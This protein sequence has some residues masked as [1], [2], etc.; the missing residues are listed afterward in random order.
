MSISFFNNRNFII[1][2]SVD[3][4]THHQLHHELVHF[5][6]KNNNRI[7]FIENTG[8]RN[9]QLK[10]FF[11]ISSRIKN[12]LKS[13]GG[14][15]LINKSLT[16][17]SPVFIPFHGNWIFDKINSLIINS[18]LLNWFSFT[19][20]KKPIIILFVPNPIS[21]SIINKIDYELLIYYVA[22]DMLLA[23][24]SNTAIKI[25]EEKIVK[26]SDLIVCT[27]ENLKRKFFKKKSKD[28][29]FLSNGVN[30]DKFKNLNLRKKI[31][32]DITI[33]FIGSIRNTI[34]QKLIIFLSK[35]FPDDRIVFVGPVIE[36]LQ[37]VIQKKLKNVFFLKQVRHSMIPK[38]L[39]NFDVGLLP[40]KVN[41]FTNSIFPIKLYEYLASGI[42]VL[43]TSTKTMIKFNDDNPNSV[44]LCKSLNDFEKRI[45]NIKKN[46]LPQEIRNKNI[47]LAHKNSWKIKFMEFEALLCKKYFSLQNKKNNIFDK[48]HSFY[49]YQKIRIFKISFVLLLS[50]L[51]F[52]V[53][54]NSKIFLKYYEINTK[55]RYYDSVIVITGFGLRGYQNISY[56]FRAKELIDYNK[57]INFKNI[58]IIGRSG[59]FDEG[60]LLVNMIDPE[61]KSKNI[62]II[63]DSGSTYNNVLK[64]KSLLD[65]SQELANVKNFSVIS[66]SIYSRRFQLVIKKNLPQLEID[67][68][69]Q[70]ESDSNYWSLLYEI[71]AI[72]KYKWNNHL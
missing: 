43:S 18:K 49:K 59:N 35:K 26:K 64:L 33:G 31:K 61:L 62:F 39:K 2:S 25:S 34:D 50:V 8:S 67:F 14:I 30:I 65:Q 7:L 12:Y 72:F 19:K 36:A 63:K 51:F 13:W 4:G 66:D 16:V 55:N 60:E 27:S 57:S 53:L 69:S 15:K 5:L 71:F 46:S 40:M 24:K 47:L 6:N 44:F 41:T 56:Q 48:F 32:K 22:D 37:K 54:S 42:P 68:L 1:I 21:L 45:N 9:I 52:L 3:W 23:S 20:F 28:C 11:R 29:Y 58:I 10:D 17:F 70:N 38:V